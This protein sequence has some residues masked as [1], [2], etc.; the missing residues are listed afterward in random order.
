MATYI[1]I[2]I[3]T[4]VASYILKDLYKK[5]ALSSQ[6]YIRIQLAMC[7]HIRRNMPYQNYCSYGTTHVQVYKQTHV[8]CCASRNF[9][10]NSRASWAHA[11]QGIH[12]S[13]AIIDELKILASNSCHAVLYSRV[14]TYK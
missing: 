7:V 5:L 14:I 12:C 2:H 4:Y 9:A 3:H 1:R 10:C 13:R 11:T 8:T 6:V